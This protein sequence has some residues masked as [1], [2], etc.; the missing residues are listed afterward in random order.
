MSLKMVAL[1][2]LFSLFLTGCSMLEQKVITKIEYKRQHID[3][4]L[5]SCADEPP[6]PVKITDKNVALY[7]LELKDAG[8]DCRGKVRAIDKLNSGDVLN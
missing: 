7:V 1:V 3:P 4:S 2:L 8:D 6:L 5:L